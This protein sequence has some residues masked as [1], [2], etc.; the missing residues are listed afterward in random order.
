MPTYILVCKKL[1][2]F[3]PSSLCKLF[4]LN[5]TAWSITRKHYFPTKKNHFSVEILLK[6][7][8][9]PI[10]IF[11]DSSVF[12]QNFYD[13]FFTSFGFENLTISLVTFSVVFIYEFRVLLGTT[14]SRV[15]SFVIT[16]KSVLFR[17]WLTAFMLVA[18]ICICDEAFLSCYIEK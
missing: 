6:I 8:L 1:T 10:F 2:L 16:V 15:K 14:P 5:F 11:E 9:H 18:G 7:K 13:T 17:N 12:S 4:F 3:L